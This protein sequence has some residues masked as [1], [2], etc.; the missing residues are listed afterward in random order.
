MPD[1]PVLF[2]IRGHIAQITFNRPE[3]R[4][5]MNEETLPAFRDALNQAREDRDLRCLIISGSG[6]TFCAGAD[7]KSGLFDQDDRLPHQRLMDAYGPFLDV[8]KLDIPVIAAMNGHAVGG[9]FGLTL[10]CDIRIAR[11]ESRYGANFAR[12][13]LHSGMA[14]AYVL[15]MVVGLPRA[16]EL[17]FT[18]RLIT[19]K[20]AADIGLANY[21]LDGEA[22]LEKAWELATEIAAC[23]PAAVQMIKKAVR[24]GIRWDP[25]DAAEIDALYQSRTFE[26]A[27][28]KEGIGALLE[29]REPVFQGR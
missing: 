7:F 24:R 1:A 22:V 28:A 9:G 26:M 14:V 2:D 16:S 6:N 27:D 13:G 25:R 21:A 5:S 12:L 23:A 10:M 19:G 18:G 4:N 11:R 15:P 17:L 8:G 3:N 20:T 29:G